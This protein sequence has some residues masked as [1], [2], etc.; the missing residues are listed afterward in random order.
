[1]PLVQRYFSGLRREHGRESSQVAYL[2]NT[3]FVYLLLDCIKYSYHFPLFF[4]NQ[5]LSVE[6]S[7]MENILI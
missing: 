2:G 1:M 5:I 6:K 7:K 4:I 3:D